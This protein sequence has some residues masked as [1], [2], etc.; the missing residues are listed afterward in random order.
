M[1]LLPGLSGRDMDFSSSIL[2]KHSNIQNKMHRAIHFSLVSVDIKTEQQRAPE[3]VTG[4]GIVMAEEPRVSRWVLGGPWHLWRSWDG[5]AVPQ[6]SLAVVF[7]LRMQVWSQLL[8]L[9]KITHLSMYTAGITS[10]LALPLIH[11]C[12]CKL[13]VSVRRWKGYR[14]SKQS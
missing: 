4:C 1:D 9:A 5:W 7:S 14:I 13:L 8:Y 11:Q 6:H 2:R 10:I 3:K 12:K